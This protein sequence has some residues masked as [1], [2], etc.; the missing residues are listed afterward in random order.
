MKWKKNEIFKKIVRSIKKINY[1]I[2]DV[3]KLIKMSI[4]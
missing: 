1:E 4:K 3:C 2:I